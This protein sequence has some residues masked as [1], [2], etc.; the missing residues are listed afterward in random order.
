MVS[1]ADWHCW[2]KGYSPQKCKKGYMYDIK[3]KKG[4]IVLMHDIHA[5][6]YIM[7]KYMLPELIDKGYKFIT[8]D[9]VRALD[10]YETDLTIQPVK[11]YKEQLTRICQKIK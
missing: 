5:K 7:L 3:R 9:E 4:G 1:A 11:Q 10:K 2:K 6:T 8:L